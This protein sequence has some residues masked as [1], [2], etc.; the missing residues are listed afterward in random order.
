M[1]RHERRR[2]AKDARKGNRTVAKVVAV[3]EAGHALARYLTAEAL[4]FEAD[5]AIAYIE[6]AFVPLP[7]ASL[8]G[9]ATLSSSAVTF[10]PMYSMAMINHLQSNP[11]PQD[12]GPGHPVTIRAEVA[13]CKAAGIDVASWA[14]LK[15]FVCMAGAAAEAKFT[16]RPAGEVVNGYECEND[17]SDAVRDCLL[18]GMTSAEAT[19]VANNALDH[20][21]TAFADPRQW[22]A[23]LALADSLP[24]SGRVQGQRAAAIIA[25][26]LAS[27]A[28]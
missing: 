19:N 23:V 17:L 20:A 1:N 9:K 22:R 25:R 27:E 4:G 7:H 6:V 5:E 24:V 12:M 11:V 15:A 26:A 14:A 2:A 13:A 28:A 10:G 8:D 3:H 16:G 18:A 21:E